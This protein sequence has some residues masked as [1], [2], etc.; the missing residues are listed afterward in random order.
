[1]AEKS[2][3]GKRRPSFFSRLDNAKILSY[4]LSSIRNVQND[5]TQQVLVRVDYENIQF[6]VE[7]VGKCLQ[8]T[9]T[10]ESKELQEF[11]LNNCEEQMQF[12]LSLSVLL[13]C[14]NVFGHTNLSMTSLTMSCDTETEMFHM[15]LEYD[16]VV[17]ECDMNTLTGDDSETDFI[18]LFRSSPIINKAII[19]SQYL[20]DAFQ[21]LTDMAGAASVILRLSPTE[22]NFRMCAK[23]NVGSCYIDFPSSSE[24]FVLFQSSR[25]QS[26]R[27]RLAFLQHAFRALQ[28]SDQTYLRIN[29]DGLLCVQH[30]VVSSSGATTYIDFVIMP[31]ENEEEEEEEEEGEEEEFHQESRNQ[32]DRNTQCQSQHISKNHSQSQSQS[33]SQADDLL[34][35]KR[36]GVE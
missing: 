24:S 15:L 7:D 27:Y 14:V 12:R 25:R 32:M 6:Q 2:R 19:K 22:P 5:S 36:R 16:G 3:K 29:E 13:D 28:H 8:A 11:E 1:M 34:Q 31:A 30:M 20:R 35:F 9:A 10:L 4:L 17:T 26:L 23:G 18:Q 21:E 33:Q